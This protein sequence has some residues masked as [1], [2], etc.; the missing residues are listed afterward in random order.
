MFGRRKKKERES[1]AAAPAEDLRE[2][3]EDAGEDL[4][5]GGP[6][7]ISEVEDR[8]GRMDFGS[9]LIPQVQGVG[10][11]LEV[12]EKGNRPRAVNLDHKGSTVQLQ[13]FAAPRTTGIWDEIRKD[14]M[15]SLRRGDGAPQAVEGPFGTE[16]RARFPA[17][18]SDGTKGYRPARFIGIDGPRWFLRAVISGP[19]AIEPKASAEFDEMIRT[20]VV[21][22]GSEPMPPRDLLPL[23]VP[24]GVQSKPVARR[25]AVRRPAQGQAAAQEGRG[26]GTSS[27][28]GSAATRPAVQQRA[29]MA[30][31]QRG[32]EITETR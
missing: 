4:R 16:L 8:E 28:T 22:R 24:E 1:A 5:A 3:A 20:V 19:A 15:D 11:R 12:N 25:R 2:D 14:L 27:G 32:P 7:D 26:A 9:L 6:W 23:Q 10:I 31:P 21:R 29:P 18:T 30:P 13:A 17:T